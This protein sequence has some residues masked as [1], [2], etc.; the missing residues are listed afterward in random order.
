MVN[1]VAVRDILED[2]LLR[3]DQLLDLDSLQMAVRIVHSIRAIIFLR[4]GVI[5]IVEIALLQYELVDRTETYGRR[6]DVI[7]A[8]I[9]A[10]ECQ[11][12][13]IDP[14]CLHL[15]IDLLGRAITLDIL[16][17]ELR[18]IARLQLDVVAR[19]DAGAECA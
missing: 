3:T 4:D 18:C 16:T 15:T 6:A 10:R 17:L 19:D 7:V 9:R 1:I 11:S 13:I 5:R 2:I 12:R 8:C 14:V